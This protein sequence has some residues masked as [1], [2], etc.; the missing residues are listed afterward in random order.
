MKKE[1]RS[2]DTWR[3]II[4]RETHCPEP[5]RFKKYRPKKIKKDHQYLREIINEK[6]N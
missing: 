3:G 4:H 6:I 2:Y 5:D 1:T